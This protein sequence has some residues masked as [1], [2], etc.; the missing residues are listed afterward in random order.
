MPKY[1]IDKHQLYSNSI[2]NPIHR[3]NFYVCWSE[4][5]ERLRELITHLS[6]DPNIPPLNKSASASMYPCVVEGQNVP[7]I[8][9]PFIWDR[10]AKQIASITHEA[11][12]AVCYFFRCMEIPLPKDMHHASYDEE[13]F[14]YTLDWLVEFIIDSLDN[15]DKHK[16]FL[17][18]EHPTRKSKPPKALQQS[19]KRNR[20]H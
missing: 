14:C 18:N 4:S 5:K 10:S 9:L 7:I 1:I 16:S 11:M 8:C 6:D 19:S 15:Q 3:F 12:H 2:Y 13:N 17:P 20:M